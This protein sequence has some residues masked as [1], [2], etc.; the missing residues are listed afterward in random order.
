MFT[1]Y[2]SV[3]ALIIATGHI[4]I[5]RAP[6][7]ETLLLWFLVIEVGVAG[8]WPFLGH[9]FKSDEIAGYIGRPAGNPFQKE[10]AFTNLSLGTC[11]VMCF[12]FRDVFWPA[13][14]VFASVFRWLSQCT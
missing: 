2:L 7:I 14:I 4:L 3:A 6:A 13:T 9:Y 8:I 11:G 10:V 1:N 12:L 5:R